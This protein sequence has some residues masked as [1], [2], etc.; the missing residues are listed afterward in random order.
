VRIVTADGRDAVL[1]GAAAVATPPVN[2]PM[3]DV[4]AR[5]VPGTAAA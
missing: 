4:P 3:G 5:E 1:A 2:E